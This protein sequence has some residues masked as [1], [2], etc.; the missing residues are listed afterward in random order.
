M[1]LRHG[2]M[3]DGTADLLVSV[4]GPRQG[5]FQDGLFAIGA[6]H[7]PGSPQGIP[8][9]QSG[10]VIMSGPVDDTVLRELLC[11]EGAEKLSRSSSEDFRNLG[12]L[13]LKALNLARTWLS[14]LFP[15]IVSR[16]HRVHYG[17]TSNCR[18]ADEPS[19]WW[20]TPIIAGIGI[21]HGDVRLDNIMLRLDPP[22]FVLIDYGGSKET[23]WAARMG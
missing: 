17:L 7:F 6:A 10:T 16:I 21:L 18:W 20:G 1:P 22:S 9:Q 19:S 3:E 12:D 13:Q 11:A 5:P 8:A 2:V 14:T 15:H 23:I 4:L